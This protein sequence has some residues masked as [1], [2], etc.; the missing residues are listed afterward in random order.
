MSTPSTTPLDSHLVSPYAP[1]WAREEAKQA[2][3]APSLPA[4]EI[5]PS[6]QAEAAPA[7]PTLQAEA[8]LSL[9]TAN[10]QLD[11]KPYQAPATAGKDEL[12]FR[13][14][15]YI[16]GEM[17]AAKHGGKPPKPVRLS[18]ITRVASEQIA[19]IKTNGHA[20]E[21]I[22]DGLRVPPSLVPRSLEPDPV[23]E[24]WPRPRPRARGRNWAVPLFVRFG[25][26][27]T[28]AAAVAVLVVQDVPSLVYGKL[29]GPISEFSSSA[30]AVFSEG[31][32]TSMPTRLAEIAKEQERAPAPAPAQPIAVAAIAPAPPPQAPARNQLAAVK[33]DSLATPA[34]E[35]RKEIVATTPWPETPTRSEPAI[36]LGP[37]GRAPVRQS[38]TNGSAA[39]PVSQE[40]VAMLRK[41]GDQYVAAGDFVG[42]R[43]VLERAA[44]AGDASAALALAATYD[45][46]VLTRFKVKGL[47]PD[48]VKA[49][50]W[51]ERAR[52][53]GSTEAPRRLEALA[54]AK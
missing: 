17:V 4:N 19:A 30:A 38:A 25:F 40:D 28:G 43:V 15:E 26:A 42:A 5:A 36:W 11:W 2:E 35:P 24:P 33:S 13:E 51:Y 9:V 39:R 48:I 41:Q 34:P 44:D 16:L 50:F 29:A 27:A 22:I 18:E 23:P 1:K 7:T 45:P 46:A 54:R 32:T 21:L 53:L 20:D 14:V 6:L 12:V 10:D 31:A 37:A 49:G 3:P 47:T 8:A 52:A